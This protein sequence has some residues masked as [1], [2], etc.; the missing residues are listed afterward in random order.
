L[1]SATFSGLCG[2]ELV[3]RSSSTLVAEWAWLTWVAS[4][5]RVLE[6]VFIL[7]EP[8]S[9]SRRIF[10]GSNLLPPLWFTVSVLHPG[11]PM[12][13]SHGLTCHITNR[14][15]LAADVDE[16]VAGDMVGLP[17]GR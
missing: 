4:Q 13:H 8:P 11:V 17:H 1:C 12:S 3:P 5:R 14:D 7:L 6:A 10:I 9:P 2:R 15:E 16:D